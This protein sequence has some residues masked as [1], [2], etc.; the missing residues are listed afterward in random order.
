MPDRVGRGFDG[1]RGAGTPDLWDRIQ[2]REPA[3]PPAEP[4]PAR[5][6]LIAT[7][8]LS[9][10]V[11]GLGVGYLAFG[12]NG[13]TAATTGTNVPAPERIAFTASEPLPRP[14]SGSTPGSSAEAPGPPTQIYTV[15]PDGSDLRQL[16]DD[17][18][19]KGSLV[20]SPDGSELAFT[21]YDLDRKVE[22][23]SVMSFDG[24]GR[25]L[26]CE[27]CTGTFYAPPDDAGCFEGCPD[28]SA[29]T[30]RLTW[31]PNGRWIAAP[32]T[33]DGGLALIDPA[34]G[35][36]IEAGELGA[37]SG[38]SWSADGARLAVSVD[39]DDPGLFV[40]DAA[41]V[42]ASRLLA[43]EPYSGGP[44]A[45]SPD[46]SSIAFA[47]A[48][49]VGGG[50]R[51]ELVFVDPH[52]GSTRTVLDTDDLFEIYDLKWSPDG[53]RLAVLHH[54]VDPPTAALL[55]VAADGSDVR[56]LALCENGRD[57]DGLCSSNGGSVSWSSDGRSLAFL[58]GVGDRAFTVV[59]LGGRDVPASAVP[60]SGDLVPSC[61]L[62]WA[63]SAR[64]PSTDGPAASVTVPDVI[65]LRL[66]DAREVLKEASLTVGRVT[67]E[68]ISAPERGVVTQVPRPGSVVHPGT[69]VALSFVDGATASDEPSASPPSN[70]LHVSCE[71]GE[72]TVLTPSVEASSDGLHVIVE[73]DTTGVEGVLLAN[74][75]DPAARESVWSSGD[76]GVDDEFARPVPP[77]T[78]HVLC[79]QYGESVASDPS[80]VAGW[81]AFDVSAPLFTPYSLS[82]TDPPHDLRT[83]AIDGWTN[84]PEFIR[85]RVDAAVPLQRAVR[86]GYPEESGFE[87]WTVSSGGKTVGAFM[88]RPSGSVVQ[89][90][91]CPEARL[92]ISP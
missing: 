29:P 78:A 35:E 18:A 58:N 36:T 41:T 82:C 21:S 76:L 30:D 66:G 33:W 91:G 53:A 22:Q 65:G 50:W 5:R 80:A 67:V 71:G 17:P 59:T 25:R 23:L 32:L 44:P 31:S 28:P 54:P 83:V 6:V 34:T 12:G 37:V 20:W 26:V 62:A 69:A 38:T 39:G 74:S 55:T 63:T 2:A 3:R 49:K 85:T 14:S 84:A 90:T 57:A 8:A 81:P 56:M 45:W 40:V 87:W 13:S 70:E 43:A 16:T 9:V 1:L 24:S 42:S 64:E 73:G 11:A 89:A 61:C 46:G 15:N 75:S 51:A 86:A 47:Q 19:L 27:A 4:G 48:I 7:F 52:D 60:V 79:V 10:A 68:S 92:T 88:F 72:T 77:G